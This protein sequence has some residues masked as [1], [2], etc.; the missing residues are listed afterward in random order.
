MVKLIRS[1]KAFIGVTNDG[2][3]APK[4]GG[5]RVKPG[6]YSIGCA[7]RICGHRQKLNQKGLVTKIE[8]VGRRRQ[9]YH[10]AFRPVLISGI[11]VFSTG[12]GMQQILPADIL[13]PT[14][15]R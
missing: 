7:D 8:K 5:P 3:A 6:D 13:T 10:A 14:A 9:P 4:F 1:A 12:Y 11:Q 2:R 15:L